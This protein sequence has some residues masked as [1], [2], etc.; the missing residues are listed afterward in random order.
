MQSQPV[1]ANIK[2]FVANNQEINRNSM[3]ANVDE[4]TLW[5]IYYPPFEAA[6]KAG[7]ASVMCS[8]NKVN[9]VYSCANKDTLW[10]DLRQLMGFDGFVYSDWG[11]VYGPD[12]RPY[13]EAGCDSE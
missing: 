6:V 12:P 7:V 1:L 9:H 13:L 2:H 5:E 11:A 10:R 3:S 8:Y 4:R